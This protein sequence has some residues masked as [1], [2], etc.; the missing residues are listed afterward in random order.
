MQDGRGCTPL[1]SLCGG[2]HDYPFVELLIASG[3]DPNLTFADGTSPLC[4]ILGSKHGISLKDRFRVIRLL[5]ENGANV[6]HMPNN[7]FNCPMGLAIASDDATAI[8][9]LIE[10][11]ANVNSPIRVSQFGNTNPLDYAKRLNKKNAISILN[12]YGAKQS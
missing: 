11:G 5:L 2:T 6:N 7:T 3:A 8:E 12:K 10:F 4:A 1:I 9:I